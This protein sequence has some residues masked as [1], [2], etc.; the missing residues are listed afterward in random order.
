MRHVRMALRDYRDGKIADAL[1]RLV[2]DDRVVLADTADELL[3]RLVADWWRDRQARQADPTRAESSMVAEHHRERRALNA[4]ARTL[5]AEAGELA[6]PALVVAGQ[7]FRRGDEV[8]C[9]TPAKEL[10]PPGQ[11]ARFV[12]NG[13]RGV[14][15]DAQPATGMTPGRLVV[16]FADRG[17]IEVP[18]EFLSR[19]L[20]P[21]VVGGLTHSYALTSYAAQ[22]DTYEAARTLATDASSRPGLYV[23]LTRGRSDSRVYA[24]RRRDLDADREREDHMPRLDDEKSAL[25]AITDRL[26]ASGYE[27]LASTLDPHAAT[28][29]DLR[30]RLDLAALIRR[31]PVRRGAR[32]RAGGAGDTGRTRRARHAGMHR[33]GARAPRPLRA[34]ASQ[35]T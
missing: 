1:A 16:D 11:R 3:D 13:T 6:G 17:P 26:A 9:R 15:I 24:V 21:G 23:G 29:G 4:R 12:R 32:P 33:T 28:V 8:I 20:R 19:R 35:R 18:M 2:R 5:L 14:V 27:H 25:Q 22:G 31:I 34:P 7:E 10:H 30:A